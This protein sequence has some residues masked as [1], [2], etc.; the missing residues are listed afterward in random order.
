MK[1]LIL[2]NQS[3]GQHLGA[4]MILRYYY[5]KL[6]ANVTVKDCNGVSAGDLTTYL[7][8]LDAAAYD[9][10]HVLITADASGG[11]GK[12]SYDQ[13]AGLYPKLKATVLPTAAS[14]GDAQTNTTETNIILASTASADDDAYNLMVAV[15]DVGKAGTSFLYRSISDYTGSSKIAVTTTTTIAVT[16]TD[17]YAV[18]NLNTATGPIYIH[19][20]ATAA[21]SVFSTFY[22][23][24]GLPKFIDEMRAAT[25]EYDL[26]ATADSVANT[27]G[28]GTLSDSA[29]FTLAK[30]DG[31][32]Y[33]VGIRSATLGMGQI[34]K[35]VSN[36]AGVLTLDKP[37]DPL[38]TGTIVYEITY[39]RWRC[40]N[41]YFLKYAMRYLYGT[42]YTLAKLE[43]F[44]KM[45]DISSS[46]T[47]TTTYVYQDLESLDSAHSLG[48]TIMLALGK[49]ITS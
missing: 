27:S 12:V 31:G 20:S 26:T 48:E 44:I 46:F 3:D 10:V 23:S 40:L 6:E 24:M 16:S 45:I 9:K 22:P 29:A 8:A 36:T 37:W 17:S 18:Y 15:V 39:N 2:L 21:H 1:G 25:T 34:R 47:T 49:G 13:L 28:I 30:Y 43:Q 33:Y 5:G 42:P 32:D 35:I 38:P 41:D 7:D 11:T 19:T 14:A 4:E